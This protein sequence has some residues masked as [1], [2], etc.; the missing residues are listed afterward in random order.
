MNKTIIERFE[1]LAKLVKSAFADDV[2]EVAA[3]VE[4]TETTETETVEFA[5]VTLTDGETVLSYEGDLAPGTAIFVNADG[6]Q[7]PAPEGTHAL[8][9]DF[10]GVSIVVDADGIILEVIDER[11]A[12]EESESEEAMSSEDVNALVESKLSE[13]DAILNAIADAVEGFTNEVKTTLSEFK[14]DI[15]KLKD[16]PSD[17]KTETKKFSR[18]EDVEEMTPA[19]RRL[20]KERKNK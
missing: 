20:L 13:R 16:A 2:E 4:T 9:G 14:A 1:D 17:T 3:D 12:T 5:E 15:E 19:Q 18:A 8:S 7:V 11:E 6:E 10:E